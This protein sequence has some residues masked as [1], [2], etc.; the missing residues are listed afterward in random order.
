[1]N[2]ATLEEGFQCTEVDSDMDACLNT[3]KF[4]NGDMSSNLT[5]E[6]FRR[7]DGG[8]G[9]A[10]FIC[11]SA[12]AVNMLGKPH[13][14]MLL[15]RVG[16]G[17]TLTAH[18]VGTLPTFRTELFG[19]V[20]YNEKL[21]FSI[22]SQQ[23][24][25]EDRRVDFWYPAG[26]GDGQGLRDGKVCCEL[27]VAGRV[28]WLSITDWDRFWGFSGKKGSSSFMTFN[29]HFGYVFLEVTSGKIHGAR[30]ISL[31]KTI[32]EEKLF[33]KSHVQI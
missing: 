21:G 23:K 6:E 15:D 22:L 8:S 18:G 5:E 20:Q 27:Q 13:K 2:F 24:L 16:E 1:M 14:G 33:V 26:G 3:C 17:R 7:L 19:V 30:L 4:L 31:C 9:G 29:C 10:G 32:L 25:S 11:D 12:S 28:F